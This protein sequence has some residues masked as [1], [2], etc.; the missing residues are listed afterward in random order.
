MQSTT[1]ARSVAF[2]WILAILFGGLTV[3]GIS[4]VHELY[5]DH[6]RL[7][8]RKEILHEAEQHLL[9]WRA[10]SEQTVAAIKERV[11]NNNETLLKNWQAE[12][13]AS[14]KALAGMRRL[15]EALQTSKQDREKLVKLLKE[16][17]IEIPSDIHVGN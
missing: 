2:L 6:Y 15:E 8:G 13:E 17:K 4:R 9:H 11:S 1:S 3:Y 16:N 14:V 7:Q 10:E 12:Q 5:R